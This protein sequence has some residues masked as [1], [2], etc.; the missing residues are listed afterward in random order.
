MK[1]T[2]FGGPVS[3]DRRTISTQRVWVLTAL[4]GVQLWAALS[5]LPLDPGEGGRTFAAEAGAVCAVLAVFGLRSVPIRWTVRG[6]ALL[7]GMLL[8][9]FGELGVLGGIGGSWRVLVWLAAVGGALALAPSSRSIPGA[10]PGIVVRADA[11]PR[12]E[13]SEVPDATSGAGPRVG[14]VPWTLLFAAVALVSAAGLLVGPRAANAFPTGASA[15]D[16]IDLDDIG[17][18]SPLLSTDRLDMTTRPRLSEQ[19]VM[20]VRS[21]IAS[22]WRTE[23]FDQWDGSTWSRTD[24]GQG[25]ILSGGVV[26]PDPDDL[27]AE[28]GEAS[29][30]EFRI[31]VGV[32][33]AVPT[34]PSALQVDS[35]QVL[36]QRPD[37][38]LVTASRPL[39]QGAT[40]VVQSRQVPSTPEMLRAATGP[41]PERI[42]SRYAAPPP[43]TDRVVELARQVTAGATNDFDRVRAIERWMDQNTEYSLD[44]P[45]SPAGVDVVDEFLFESQLGWCEQIASS[46]VVMARLSGVPARLATGFTPGEWD[47][48]GSRFVVRERDAHAWAEVWFP[49]VGWVTFDPTAEVPL[50]G[51]EEATP[52]AAAIDWREVVGALLLIA[53]VVSLSVGPWRRW[54]ARRRVRRAAGLEDRA[55]RSSPEAQAEADIERRGREVGRPRGPE[56]TISVYAGAVAHRVGDPSIED[57]GQDLD[58][59]Y[60]SPGDPSH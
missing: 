3:P 6:M 1:L 22:F 57:L 23:V 10:A 59:R 41:I 31:E 24:E 5:S 40:Y 15:G 42:R 39:S 54:R 35:A 12:P 26:E 29:R 32:A 37:G 58:R 36:A 47:E 21:P 56:E 33:T 38:T 7:S 19:V 17:Q 49:E 28:L 4:V 44:A 25:S 13:S 53:G 60:Y 34:A 9:R 48:V 14:A 30:Q 55:R 11:V 2:G 51:T 46:L 50:A 20:S 18:N 52:G 45:L 16:I 43:A 8:G 27:A